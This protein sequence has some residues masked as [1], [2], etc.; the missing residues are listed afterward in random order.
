MNEMKLVRLIVS[1]F[2]DRLRFSWLKLTKNSWKRTELKTTAARSLLLLFFSSGTHEILCIWQS[3]QLLKD[4]RCNQ[5]IYKYLIYQKS[6][7][8]LANA[9][10]LFEISDLR[11]AVSLLYCIKQLC[12]PALWV[13]L[14]DFSS[15]SRFAMLNGGQEWLFLHERVKLLSLILRKQKSNILRN[16][17]EHQRLWSNFKQGQER[18]ATVVWSLLDL[19]RV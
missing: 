19:V 14:F 13:E 17:S 4:I 9:T 16:K 7:T 3:L 11:I 18:S 2:P 10:I 8:E 1:P 5:I 12:T 6:V 15:W